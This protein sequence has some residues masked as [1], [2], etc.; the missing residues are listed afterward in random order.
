MLFRWCPTLPLL[1]AALAQ[2]WVVVGCVAG[3][4]GASWLVRRD[5]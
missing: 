3:Q 5:G 4:W 2:G 1:A